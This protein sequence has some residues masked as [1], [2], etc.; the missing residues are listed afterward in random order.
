M[1]DGLTQ[2]VLNLSKTDQAQVFRMLT[3]Y[4]DVLTKIIPNSPLLVGI[5]RGMPVDN[6]AITQAYNTWKHG[7]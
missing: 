2:N 7:L 6:S 4:A 5:V 3:D 1:L